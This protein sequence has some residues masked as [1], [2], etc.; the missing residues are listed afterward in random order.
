MVLLVVA[1]IDRICSSVA[2]YLGNVWKTSSYNFFLEIELNFYYFSI[3]MYINMYVFCL[4]FWKSLFIGIGGLIMPSILYTVLCCVTNISTLHF[5][6]YLHAIIWVQNLYR[7][8]CRYVEFNRWFMY[9]EIDCK[10]HAL[11]AMPSQAS[12]LAEQEAIDIRVPA[13]YSIT[14]GETWLD[15]IVTRNS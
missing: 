3:S 11:I 7:V 8:V 2:T 15:V 13:N 1:V 6:S 14:R 4:W 10:C 12:N 5:T 9:M